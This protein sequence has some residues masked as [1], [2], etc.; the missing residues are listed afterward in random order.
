MQTDSDWAGKDD[1]RRSVSGGSITVDGHWVRSW[2]K[3]QAKVARSSGEAELYAGNDG[4]SQGMGLQSTMKELG[5]PAPLELQVDAN[6]TI[7]ILHRRGLGT[8]RHLEVEELWLQ[9]ELYKE[10]LKV[11]KVAGKTT[12]RTL[13]QKQ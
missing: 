13:E 11:K 6:A 1:K 5:W 4:A 3:D 7:G 8:M 2:S 10:Q 9:Q 12:Q